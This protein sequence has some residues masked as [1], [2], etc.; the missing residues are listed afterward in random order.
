MIGIGGAARSD[1][2]QQGDWP[3]TL[4]FPEVGL[5]RSHFCRLE[6]RGACTRAHARAGSGRLA[7]PKKRSLLA[8][9]R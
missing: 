1:L 6:P 4:L 9:L 8:A 7:A 3:S 5:G 2:A